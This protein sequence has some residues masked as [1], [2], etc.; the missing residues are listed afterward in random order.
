MFIVKNCVRIPDICCY[1][2]FA[3]TIAWILKES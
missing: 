1:L 3:A 2:I